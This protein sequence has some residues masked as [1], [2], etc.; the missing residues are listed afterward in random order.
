MIS[1]VDCQVFQFVQL[2]MNFPQ[3]EFH[4]NCY[5]SFY[6]YIVPCSVWH[7][8][9]SPWFSGGRHHR[10]VRSNALLVDI[11]TKLRRDSA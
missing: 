3:F 4:L 2:Q 11:V 9:K 8:Q 6:I 1:L 7:W 5:S 10:Q